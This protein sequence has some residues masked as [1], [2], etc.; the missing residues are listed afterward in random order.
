MSEGRMRFQFSHVAP[1]PLVQTDPELAAII[2]GGFTRQRNIKLIA[3]AS[4]DACAPP[5]P[6]PLLFGEGGRIDRRDGDQPSFPV[7]ATD[8]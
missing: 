8:F 5:G 4:V 6:A 1:V 7:A 2:A 3:S